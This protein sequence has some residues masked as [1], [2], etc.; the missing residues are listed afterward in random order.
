MAVKL[1]KRRCFSLHSSLSTHGGRRDSTSR[2][3]DERDE[4]LGV[5][6]SFSRTVEGS[7]P[8][9]TDPPS[10]IYKGGRFYGLETGEHEE[11]ELSGHGRMEQSTPGALRGLD[12]DSAT[13]S[14]D[15]GLSW[16][17]SWWGP[18]LKAIL[19]SFFSGIQF[20]FWTS[21]FHWAECV[22]AP[23][24][25]GIFWKNFALCLQPSWDVHRVVRYV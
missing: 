24:S 5:W 12:S 1:K 17:A 7:G 14:N 8:G 15:Q 22:L 4:R 19:T 11:R 25:S 2:T 3:F 13:V 20:F 6:P 9:L 16:R 21:S 23:F 18:A 10:T